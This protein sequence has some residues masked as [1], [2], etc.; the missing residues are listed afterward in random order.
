M[1]AWLRW[2]RT[3][4][5]QAQAADVKSTSPASN[6]EVIALEEDSDE[7]EKQVNVGVK[8]GKEGGKD[9]KKLC[10]EKCEELSVQSENPKNYENV[11]IDVEKC[12]K[13]S[14][15]EVDK[16]NNEIA[17]LRKLFD[18][19]SLVKEKEKQ[20]EE[21][22]EVEKAQQEK[23]FKTKETETNGL[24][25]KAQDVVKMKADEASL[26][27][28]FDQKNATL[29]AKEKEL[30]A[31]K[32]TLA[33]RSNDVKQPEKTVE[34]QEKGLKA[35]Q[36][37]LAKRSKFLKQLEKTPESLSLKLLLI[38]QKDKEL[39]KPEDLEEAKQL[40]KGG[41]DP[42]A[43]RRPYHPN[44]PCLALAVL[45]KNVELVELLL[46]QPGINVNQRNENENAALHFACRRGG[47]EAILKMLLNNPEIDL[48][49]RNMKGETPIMHAFYYG[50]VKAIRRLAF[51]PLVEL[52]IKSEW[53]DT[54][55]IIA[56]T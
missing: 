6:I 47:P 9:Y 36:D 43:N 18:E 34:S 10:E 17:K 3:S 23:L 31:H 2:R 37:T 33:V 40:L 5:P 26:K 13:D 55:D 38:C 4:Q 19:Q 29:K 14:A 54:L 51:D 53:G 30:K 21:T 52:D 25:A 35:Y 42:N 44:I 27:A 32:D 22:T 56:E 28:E 12:V 50:N 15:G 48:N 20:K 16:K 39:F 45:K 8:Q 7:D 46:M 1:H 11:M 49:P 41:A 24:K